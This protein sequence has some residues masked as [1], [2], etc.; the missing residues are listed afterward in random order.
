MKMSIKTV[1]LL[2]SMSSG[3]PA[4]AVTTE[5]NFVAGSCSSSSV[6]LDRGTKITVVVNRNPQ[7]E[8][9]NCV[10]RLFHPKSGK[11]VSELNFLNTGY[12][13]ISD[14]DEYTKKDQTCSVFDSGG[15]VGIKM[16]DETIRGGYTSGYG[17]GGG[18]SAGYYARSP[19]GHGTYEI[20]K[21]F[22][23]QTT[24]TTPSRVWCDVRRL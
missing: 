16:T 22:P 6:F 18:S 13:Y 4:M 12:D 9:E 23:S 17:R 20:S 24:F 2:L 5:Y 7:G 15:S 21:P 3:I 1:L 19:E 14:G 8:I 11:V 10:L